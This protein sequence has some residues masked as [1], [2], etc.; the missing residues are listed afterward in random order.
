MSAKCTTPGVCM[1][2]TV[3]LTDNVANTRNLFPVTSSF[4]STSGMRISRDYL[5]IEV[6]TDVTTESYATECNCKDKAT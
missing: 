3:L 2:T 5:P 6:D 4:E 1:H